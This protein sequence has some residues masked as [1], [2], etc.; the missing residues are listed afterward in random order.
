M[1][2]TKKILYSGIGEISHFG[3]N[4]EAHYV[5]VLRFT[6]HELDPLSLIDV[7]FQLPFCQH[8]LSELNS[9]HES[10]I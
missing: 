9:M 1:A 3:A 7:A 8:I 2:D 10:L 6:H 5:A 4:V